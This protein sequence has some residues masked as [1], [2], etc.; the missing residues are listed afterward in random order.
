MTRLERAEAWLAI[1]GAVLV[2]AG[3]AIGG[4]PSPSGAGAVLFGVG[5]VIAGVPAG[6]RLVSAASSRRTAE[7]G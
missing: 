5:I 3:W 6:R 7:R 1:L 2:I 4:F